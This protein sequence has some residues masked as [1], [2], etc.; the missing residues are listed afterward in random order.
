MR[1]GNEN[2]TWAVYLMT[3]HNRTV[4]FTAVCE[5]KEW[6]AM[7]LSRPGYHQLLQGGIATEVEAEDLAR[8]HVPQEMELVGAQKF[9][10][11]A[12]V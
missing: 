5:Q 1:T 10:M 8:R 9:K 4:R 11:P 3:I 12:V 2:P 6:E 7:E